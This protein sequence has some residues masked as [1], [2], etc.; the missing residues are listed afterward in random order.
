MIFK[1]KKHILIVKKI[2]KNENDWIEKVK[3]Y[4]NQ[5][6]ISIEY[7]KPIIEKAKGNSKPLEVLVKEN[8]YKDMFLEIFLEEEIGDEP[9]G[10]DL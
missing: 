6:E 5:N 1:M 7:Q 9:D 10:A 3:S 2:I 8:I 4:F